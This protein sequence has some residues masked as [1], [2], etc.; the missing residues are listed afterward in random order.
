MLNDALIEDFPAVTI[1]TAASDIIPL[2]IDHTMPIPVVDED[3]KLKGLVY[4]A[5]V[6][7]EVTGRE[8]E[9]VLKI[10]EEGGNVNE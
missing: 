8:E 3:R 10:K 9:E 2:F 5:A 6:V 7:A 1:D 4:H